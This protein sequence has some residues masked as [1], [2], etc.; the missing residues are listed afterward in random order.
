MAQ[1]RKV[2]VVDPTGQ[3]EGVFPAND[4]I[5]YADTR[6]LSYT[7]TV[8]QMEITAKLKD[9]DLCLIHNQSVNDDRLGLLF[10]SIASQNLLVLDSRKTAEKSIIKMELL[11]DEFQLP[12]VWFVLN[13]A[14][15]NP[16][17]FVEI[18]K[19]WRKYFIKAKS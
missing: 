18:Q 5:N 19:I 11:K 9:Y 16:S 8:F 6:F 2:L 14:G 15:Y 4:Y 17:V 7:K 3:L 10:M 12:N 1:G 13:K